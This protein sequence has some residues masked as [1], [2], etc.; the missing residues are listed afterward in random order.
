MA[1]LRPPPKAAPDTPLWLSAAAML[2]AIRELAARATVE[3]LQRRHTPAFAEYDRLLSERFRE[4]MGLAALPDRV[5]HFVGWLRWPDRAGADERRALPAGFD[6]LAEDCLRA[7]W[8]QVSGSALF[9]NDD[10]LLSRALHSEG[11]APPLARLRTETTRPD[12]QSPWRWPLKPLSAAGLRP[13]SRPQAYGSYAEVWR[14]LLQSG[15]RLPS[16]WPEDHDGLS[17]WLDR[18]DALLASALHAVPTRTDRRGVPDSLYREAR[19]AAAAAAA[20]WHVRRAG[21]REDDAPS[22]LLVQAEFSPI[23]DFIFGTDPHTPWSS[24]AV[25]GARSSHVRLAMELACVAVL[26]RL[27]LPPTSLLL[28]AAS[29][30]LFLAPDTRAVREQLLPGLRHTLEEWSREA[31]YAR[32]GIHLVWIPVGAEVIARGGLTGQAGVSSTAA[33]RRLHEVADEEKHQ[34]WQLAEPGQPAVLEHYLPALDRWLGTCSLDAHAPASPTVQAPWTLLDERLRGTSAP[35]LSG[36][37]ATQ[38][39]HYLQLARPG[40]VRVLRDPDPQQPAPSHDRLRMAGLELRVDAPDAPIGPGLLRDWDLGH[41]DGD[42]GR[43]FNGHAR[44]GLAQRRHGPGASDDG[45]RAVLCGDIDRLGNAFQRGIA[46]PSMSRTIE[47]SRQLDQFFS[48]V[49]PHWLAG[50]LPAV[51]IALAGGD[52]FMFVGPW[53]QMKHL[54]GVLWTL[55]TEHACNPGVSFSAGLSVAPADTPMKLLTD[56]AEAHLALAKRTRGAIGAHGLSVPWA[57]WLALEQLEHSCREWVGPCPPEEAARL[58]R[59]LLEL[60]RG[61]ERSEELLALRWRPRLNAWL[62][63][64]ARAM[65]RRAG[66]GQSASD[67]AL[68]TVLERLDQG[69]AA[70]LESHGAALEIVLQHLL[71]EAD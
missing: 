41:D 48:L 63:R 19:L 57:Q 66:T 70:A 28:S 33:F 5:R 31:F 42:A 59:W 53:S 69:L 39:W 20:T 38:L 21:G 18:L 64:W 16:E 11:I 40:R 12:A 1:T 44:R 29:K 30:A 17:R 71:M 62:Q 14:G 27:N 56:T 50:H 36:Q 6:T 32:A 65:A 2:L 15:R 26:E 24:D 67:P 51:D 55:F 34:R 4:F 7:G 54:P 8:R 45:R 46:G 9:A 68:D 43:A 25:L 60:V 52:D 22:Y 10:Q 49:V 13:V 61:R 37:G 23:Q 3:E 35:P 47:L 58:W